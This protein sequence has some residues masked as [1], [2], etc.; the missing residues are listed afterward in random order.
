MELIRQTS[1]SQLVDGVGI[2]LHTS[3]FHE[4]VELW[5]DDE[6]CTQHPYTIH[7]ISCS[8]HFG[9]SE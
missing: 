1:F 2:C 4:L 3:L 8:P 7:K 9:P 6:Q 5:F